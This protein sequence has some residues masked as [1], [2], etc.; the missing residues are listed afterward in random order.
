ML[1]HT[2]ALDENLRITT[3]SSGRVM[4]RSITHEP[5]SD[6]LRVLMRS[7]GLCGRT[8]CSS[9]LR[10]DHPKVL[11]LWQWCSCCAS[12][13]PFL[14][15]MTPLAKGGGGWIHCFASCRIL[16]FAVRAG[17]GWRI[18]DTIPGMGQV[19]CF[20]LYIHGMGHVMCVAAMFSIITMSVCW[21]CFTLYDDCFCRTPLQMSACA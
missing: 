16:P 7:T 5:E 20:A 17:D 2:R 8:L 21:P 1:L 6:V 12:L 19:M 10:P 13:P 4:I 9:S 15:C 14:G 3:S 18:S 11:L